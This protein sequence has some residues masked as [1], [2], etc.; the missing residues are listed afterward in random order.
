M[1]YEHRLPTVLNPSGD[2][3][4]P[5]YIPL[6]PQYT[7]LLLGAL[8][9]LEETERYERDPDYDDESAKIVVNQ[10]RTRTITPLIEAIA[11][12][13]ACGGSMLVHIERKNVG[14]TKTV[15]STSK[16]ILNDLTIAHT[17][18]KAKAKIRLANLT[19]VTSNVNAT[20]EA[21]IRVA[22]VVGTQSAKAVEHSWNQQNLEAIAYFEGLNDGAPK[23]VQMYWSC[24][25]G[26]VAL[27]YSTDPIWEIVEFD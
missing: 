1:P 16:V 24:D 8:R 17:F 25:N 20:G 5:L 6:D 12:G 14:G 10:W 26:Q 21:E 7:A 19:L 18:T 11:N 2:Y 9:T 4:V 13:Q 27:A 23:N 22:G 3:C 15:T